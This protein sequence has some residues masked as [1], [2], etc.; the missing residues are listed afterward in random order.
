MDLREIGWESVV[1][2]SGS[3]QGPVTCCCECG[4]E[5]LSSDATELVCA[6]CK[7]SRWRYTA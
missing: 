5:P 7:D 1:Y 4:D 3:A 6:E 2:P